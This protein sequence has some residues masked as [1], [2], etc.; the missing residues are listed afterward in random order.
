MRLPFL[1][2]SDMKMR[3]RRGEG[4]LLSC[5]RLLEG[6]LQHC[7]NSRQLVAKRGLKGY[8]RDILTEKDI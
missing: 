2:R 3:G 8:K 4:P 1:Q 5:S 6:V 7:Y